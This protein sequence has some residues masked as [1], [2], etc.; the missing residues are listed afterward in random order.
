[1]SCGCCCNKNNNKIQNDDGSDE[2]CVKVVILFGAPGAGKGTVAQYLMD[3]YGV[4]HFSTG[5]LLRNE[6]KNGTSVGKVVEA[7]LSSGKLVEDDVVNSV[8]ET[9]LRR[10]LSGS[11]VVLLD[12][13]PRTVEQAKFLD[14]IDSGVLKSSTRVLELDVD[15]EIVVSRI[16]GRVVC[17]KCGATFSSSQLADSDTKLCPRCGG[18]LVKRADDNEEVVR[19]RLQE[20]VNMTLPV[21]KYYEDRG[22]LCKVSGEGTPEE[23]ANNVD[24]VFRNF[25]IKKK[26]KTD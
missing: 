3:N 8:V 15:H 11:D 17:S 1:M 19:H 13:Y 2:N 12:G 21:S 20:Y 22:R 10:A 25:G 14:A 9:N 18:D 26:T 16:A 7:T 4:L 5:N 23:V 6:V 24:D